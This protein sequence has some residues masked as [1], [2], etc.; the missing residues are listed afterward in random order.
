MA[1]V[2]L[3]LRHGEVPP[4]SPAGG[5]ATA[6]RTQLQ[7]AWRRFR[8]HKA[9]VAGLAVLLLLYASAILAPVLAPY[10]PTAVAL[11][12]A[13]QGPSGAHLMGT[14]NLGRDE[15]SR[16]LYGGRVSLAV[17]LAVALSAGLVGT[18]LGAVA[19]ASGRLLDGAVMRVTDF[20]LTMPLLAV[21]MMASHALGGSVLDVVVVLSLLFWMPV[22]RVVRGVFL[23]IREKE[24]IEA[25]RALGTGRW[26]LLWRHML[27]NAAG[28]II[29]NVTLGVALAILTESLLSFLGFGIQPPTP[30]WGNMVNQ[31]A[32]V[33]LTQ[34]W[35]VWFP[36]LMILVTVLAVNFLGDGLRDALDPTGTTGGRR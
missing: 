7:V 17:G 15:F 25:A 34:P 13:N 29:V 28:P 1:D 35:L 5:P 30:T 19:G 2:G 10:D 32:E 33:M 4:V 20:F 6:G 21:L 16:V 8:R 11:G 22:A 3:S 24:Y 23:S 9:A 12:E 18:T 27:P 14:D 36:G 26:R 31:G